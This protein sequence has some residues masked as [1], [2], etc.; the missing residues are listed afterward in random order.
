MENWLSYVPIGLGVIGL[1]FA[2]GLYMGV[3]RS[4]AG[5]ERMKEIADAIQKGAMAFLKRE[6]TMLALFVVVAQFVPWWL[7][8][9]LEPG[10]VSLG[11]V[12]GTDGSRHESADV[13]HHA[14]QAVD[15]ED[16]DD[17]HDDQHRHE[18]QGT[19]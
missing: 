1:L 18:R 9:R 4:A 3:A 10:Q 12:Q 8:G 7:A 15:H 14:D 13:R 5:N 2:G 6:Y 19:T 17:H 16:H 11:A